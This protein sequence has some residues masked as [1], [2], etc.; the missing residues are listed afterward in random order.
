MHALLRLSLM[1][2]TV[3]L[4][5]QLLRFAREGDLD[6]LRRVTRQLRGFAMLN[7]GLLLAWLVMLVRR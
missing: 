5:W 3:Y 7:G 4:C 6:K 2:S 1:V